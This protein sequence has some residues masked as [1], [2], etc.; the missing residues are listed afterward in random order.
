MSTVAASKNG[1]S[2]TK[3]SSAAG[4]L[5]DDALPVRD[6]FPAMVDLP[7]SIPAGAAKTKKPRRR[8]MLFGLLVFVIAAGAHSGRLLLAPCATI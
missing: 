2:H 6:D 1:N 5:D 8:K 7:P 3:S 4:L